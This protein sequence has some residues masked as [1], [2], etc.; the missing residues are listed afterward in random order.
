VK[1]TFLPLLLVVIAL[2]ACGGGGGAS[3]TPSVT[4]RTSVPGGAPIA[5]KTT[6]ATFQVE[7]PLHQTL[8][9]VGARTPQYVSP[10]T[11]FFLVDLQGNSDPQ[12]ANTFLVDS[13]H[14]TTQTNSNNVQVLSCT[15]TAMIPALDIATQNWSIAAGAGKTDGTSGPPLSVKHNVTAFVSPVDNSVTFNAFLDTIV[16]NLTNVVFGFQD[17]LPSAG[18][19][20]TVPYFMFTATDYFGNAVLGD[21]SGLAGAEQFA[22]PI[23]LTED[24]T[25]GELH[26]GLIQCCAMGRNVR[27]GPVSTLTFDRLVSPNLVAI[28]IVDDATASRTMHINSTLPVV[29]LQPS[30]FSQLATTWSSPAKTNTLL[31]I[32]C[33]PASAPT[34]NPC[35]IA[36]VPGN[37][38]IH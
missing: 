26:M 34:T 17:F 16:T 36:T 9:S 5:Q 35:S 33:V 24:D 2:A 4:A 19:T 29:N 13:T 31:T 11:T 30:E 6:R 14:C 20:T 12:F 22:N 38:I 28:Q 7:I 21:R 25:S 1:T 15:F 8:A 37:F 32:T 23:T 3:Q 27:G 18:A 10:N